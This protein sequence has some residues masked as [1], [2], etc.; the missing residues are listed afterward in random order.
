MFKLF[1]MNL[2]PFM[3]ELD[4]GSGAVATSQE[5]SSTESITETSTLSTDSTESTDDQGEGTTD[6]KGEVDAKP[7]QTPEQDRAYAE[8]RRSKEAAE[9]R[10]I[11]VETLRKRDQE[12][13]RKYGKEYNVYSDADVEA[14]W[15]KT[16]GIKT[17]AEFEAALQREEYQAKGIDPDLINKLIEDHPAIKQ[18]KEQEQARIQA[19]QDR[20]LVDSFGELTKEYPDI[21]KV[22]D[23]PADVWKKWNGG[24][25]GLSLV[26]SFYLVNRKEII[27]KQTDATRQ[28]TLNNIQGKK[29]V[30]GNGSGTD[31]DT[32]RVPDDVLAMYKK[33]NPGKTLDEYKAHYKKSL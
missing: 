13:A 32:T 21:T 9:K 27:A 7:K 20:F 22:E 25:T 17:V 31:V 3:D 1:N 10:A 23:V 11:E 33:F 5:T 29:H 24:S 6:T 28:A 14:Q 30:K 8:L 2:R 18:A 26:D 4:S 16:H 19:E 12:I 15:G